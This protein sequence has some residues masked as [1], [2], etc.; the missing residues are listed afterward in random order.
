MV[1]KQDDRSLNHSLIKLTI[2]Y[3]G[4]VKFTHC[5]LLCQEKFLN[6]YI[7]TISEY[8]QNCFQVNKFIF[9]WPAIRLFFSQSIISSKEKS[10]VD[11]SYHSFIINW[12][13]FTYLHNLSPLPYASG[14]IL[15]VL[16]LSRFSQTFQAFNALLVQLAVYFTSPSSPKYFVSCGSRAGMNAKRLLKHAY[17]KGLQYFLCDIPQIIQGN[18]SFV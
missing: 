9:S 1:S 8:I 18:T 10:M 2:H 7:S 16:H 11:N 6:K 14:P 17:L 3:L 13:V 5:L 12:T 4:L 15:I